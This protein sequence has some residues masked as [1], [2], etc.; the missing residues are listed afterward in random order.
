MDNATALARLRAL[1]PQG[2]YD[3]NLL[4]FGSAAAAERTADTPASAATPAP[5]R[6]GLI[7]S[8]VAG[9]HPA[10]RDTELHAWGCD[11]KP[12]PAEHGTEIASLLGAAPRSEERRVGKECVSTCKSR[13]SP[14]DKK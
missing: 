12:V 14:V 1:V 7:D 4:Y 10:L 2:S 11:G 8:G 6:I 13:W 3:F 9:S 5:L